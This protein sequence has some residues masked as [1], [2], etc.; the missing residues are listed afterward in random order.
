[1]VCPKCETECKCAPNKCDCKSS[2]KAC[3][4]ESCGYEYLSIAGMGIL[5]LLL[6]RMTVALSRD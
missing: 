2:N 3:T 4:K 5:F 6:M 1:M